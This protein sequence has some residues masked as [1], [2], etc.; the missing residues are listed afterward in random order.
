MQRRLHS[1][2]WLAGA[3]ALSA[4]LLTLGD[5]LHP[6]WWAMWLAPIPMLVASFRCSG[7][8]AALLVAITALTGAIGIGIGLMAVGPVPALLITIGRLLEW[9]GTVLGFRGLVR[10]SRHWA[11]PFA[12][13]VVW[14]GLDTVLTRT[15]ADGASGSLAFSQM[16]ALPVIQVAAVTGEAGIVFLIGL[17]ASTAA[18][19][20]HYG[21][22]IELP[23]LAYGLPAFVLAAALGYGTLRLQA[24][25]AGGVPVGMVAL[26]RSFEDYLSSGTPDAP[27]WDRYDAKVASLA[28]QGAKIIVLPEKLAI[29]DVRA[30]APL[31]A[32]FAAI[33][34]ARTIHLVIGIAVDAGDHVENR[35]WLFGPD[36]TLLG[37]Y[38]KQHLVPHLEDDYRPGHE[39]LV[40]P[41]GDAR[42]G[43]TIC[44]DMDF[45]PLGWGYSRLGAQAL[46]V[47]A[48]DFGADGWYHDRM[49][50]LLGVES[51]LPVIRAALQGLMTVSDRYGRVLAE[52][53]SS[54]TDAGGSLFLAAAPLGSGQPTPYARFGD[55]FGWTCVALWLW[56]MLRRRLRHRR[57]RPVEALP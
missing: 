28:G 14:A 45:P 27:L 32:R 17:F 19:A 51:G 9:L 18:V 15:L 29:V 56:L 35:S 46:L 50:V 7:R 52:A 23:A 43:L 3:A 39:D 25:E 57:I 24:T 53:P 4:A 20:L 34:R 49:A 48:W 13:P 1:F 31:Q 21:R 44:K 42:F 41:I 12:Y 16:D 2:A 6:H 37:D 40:R 36:G 5:A 22:A 30:V 55:W 8:A 47:P 33:A 11:L 10:R 26:D 38:A 54:A